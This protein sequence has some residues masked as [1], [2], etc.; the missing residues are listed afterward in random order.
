VDYYPAFPLVSD[1]ETR[2]DRPA[3]QTALSVFRAHD[4]AKR[5]VC[6]IVENLVALVAVE[7]DADLASLHVIF[8][9]LQI[10]LE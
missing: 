10:E 5:M 3:V 8:P 6:Q 9:A 7:A 1:I 4:P 2:R